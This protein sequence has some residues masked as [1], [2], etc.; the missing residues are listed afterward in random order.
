MYSQERGCDVRADKV[1]VRGLES[2]TM[3]SKLPWLRAKTT[4]KLN[5]SMTLTLATLHLN[6]HACLH[7][8][9]C[10]AAGDVSLAEPW[11]RLGSAFRSSS[12]FL[13][14]SAHSAP[15][16][17]S[18]DPKLVDVDRQVGLLVKFISDDV[19]KGSMWDDCCSLISQSICVPIRAWSRSGDDAVFRSSCQQNNIM[20]TRNWS[21]TRTVLLWKTLNH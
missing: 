20:I 4:Q 13:V 10:R 8:L 5:L 1:W 12:T 16:T 9:L 21:K 3:F 6:L 7:A 19:L 18:C 2:L 17:V 15:S 11:T 14:S